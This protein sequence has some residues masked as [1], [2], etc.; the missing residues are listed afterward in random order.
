M[1]TTAGLRLQRPFRRGWLRLRLTTLDHYLLHEVLRAAIAVTL[2]LLLLIASKLFM[3]QLGYLMEGKFSGGIVIGLLA[4]KVFVYFVHLLPFLML[5][6]SVLALGRM[7]RDAEMTALH[8][9]GYSDIR[10]LLPM[11]I[12]GVPLA[13]ALGAMSLQITPRLLLEAE[14]AHHQAR[15]EAG[16][17]LMQ[18]GRFLQTRNGRWALY[19]ARTSEQ[20]AEDVF[21]ASYEAESWRV[22]IET[23]ARVTRTLDRIRGIYELAFEDGH[24]HSGWPGDTD[25]QTMQFDRH[26]LRVNMDTP[27]NVRTQVRYWPLDQ[28][29]ADDAA[30]ARA[31]LQWRWSL[32]VS[33]LLMLALA[34][35]LSRSSAR[36]GKYAR[37]V[38][39]IIIYL[40]YAQFQL[41]ATSQVRGG[42]WPAWA[43]VWWVHALMAAGILGLYLRRRGRA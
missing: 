39:A 22:N 3:Q 2:V 21:F 25:F 17:D 43:G 26:L 19:A 18:E 20:G 30:A 42:N 10:L 27:T 16:L 23:A 37:V 14:L 36:E 15:L 24:W 40:V 11:A 29:W 8:A 6:S 13:V 28:L 7:H 38:Y 5:L 9:C 12:I 4:N 35:P 41:L 1:D 32:P 31:E 34:I 33:L